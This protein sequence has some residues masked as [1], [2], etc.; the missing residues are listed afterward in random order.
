MDQ[1]QKQKQKKKQ[2][3]KQADLEARAVLGDLHAEVVRDG[4]SAVL[5]RDQAEVEQA[6][7]VCWVPGCRQKHETSPENRQHAQYR[8]SNL[9]MLHS[10]RESSP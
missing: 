6:G 4:G 1:K 5:Q 2:K 7:G 10:C 3:Q 9:E 8:S